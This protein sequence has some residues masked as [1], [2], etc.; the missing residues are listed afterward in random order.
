MVADIDGE[1]QATTNVDNVFTTYNPTWKNN[2]Q[3]RK[4]NSHVEFLFFGADLTLISMIIRFPLFYDNEYGI[5][6]KYLHL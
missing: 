3:F 5:H 1:K 6:Q 2:L 4:S